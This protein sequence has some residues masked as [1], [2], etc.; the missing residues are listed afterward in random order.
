MKEEK[1]G[2]DGD[3]FLRSVGKSEKFLF[4]EELAAYRAL[5]RESKA[6]ALLKAVGLLIYE[7]KF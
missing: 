5:R 4:A 6:H 3:L 1:T 7:N 2:K